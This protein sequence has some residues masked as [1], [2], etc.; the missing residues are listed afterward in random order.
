M[1]DRFLRSKW[2]LGKDY[3]KLCKARVLVCGLGGVGG[4]CVDALFRTGFS[5]L[6]LI[7]MDSFDITNQNR[8]LHSEHVGEKKAEVFARL[9]KVKGICAKIDEDFLQSFSLQ[10]FDIII[11]A[12]DDMKAKV[13]LASKADLNKQIYLCS[14]GAARRMDARC[15]Q[16]ADVFKTH[17]DK[18]ASKLR[19]EL[20][21]AKLANLHFDVVFS[22]ELAKCD[23]LG[24]FMG[25]TA[26]FGLMLASLALQKYLQSLRLDKDKICKI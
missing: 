23:K 12:I 18:L 19:Y 14:C 17:T 3:E 25:V 2:L 24:S 11:D 22:T 10:D 8:Q 6:T 4:A 13:L 16:V 5:N 9:Y 21:K 7:D 15:I 20:R 1:E 26:S